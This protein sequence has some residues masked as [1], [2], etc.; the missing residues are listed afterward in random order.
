ME[1]YLDMKARH[2]KEVDDFEGVFFAFSQSQLEEGMA[3]FGLKRGVDNKKL[4][5]I[6]NGGFI[7]REKDKEFT[8]MF[9]RMNEERKNFRKEEKNLIEALVY[10]LGNHEYCITCDVTATL[11]SLGLEEKDV[12]QKILQKAINIYMKGANL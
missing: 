12:D 4:L 1:S 11:E 2:Q 10:E 3:K 5:S 6:G 8:D 7:L 9:D